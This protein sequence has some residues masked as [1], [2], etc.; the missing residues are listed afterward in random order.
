MT[1]ERAALV[2]AAR[3]GSQV[4]FDPKSVRWLVRAACARSGR[5]E[6]EGQRKLFCAASSVLSSEVGLMFERFFR[7]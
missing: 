2:D 4:R 3:T 7:A 5:S 6:G 1:T